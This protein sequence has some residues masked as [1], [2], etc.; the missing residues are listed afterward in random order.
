M[1]FKKGSNRKLSIGDSKDSLIQKA[2]VRLL[3]TYIV[4]IIYFQITLKYFFQTEIEVNVIKTKRIECMKER[5]LNIQPYIIVVG[6]SI[7][8]I[9]SSYVCIDQVVY[10]THS[11]LEALD[12]CFKI[13]HI[14]H[15]EYP[16]ESKHLWL[17]I[18]KC[19]YRISTSYDVIFSHTENIIHQ[20][21]K[22][23]WSEESNNPLERDQNSDL[24]NLDIY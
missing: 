23:S 6:K 9:T 10:A 1:K 18:Q 14:F 11:V 20:A 17:I 19:L 22:E 24:E 2:A 8:E 7:N 3:I 12:L 5:K 13:F 15:V 21:L 16:I 4:R